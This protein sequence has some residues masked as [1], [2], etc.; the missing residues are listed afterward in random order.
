MKLP[1]TDHQVA[2]ADRLLDGFCAERHHLVIALTGAHAYGF[3]S[4][5]SDLDLKGVHILPTARL[6][7]LSRPDDHAGFMEVVEGVEIDYG[8]NELGQVIAGVLRGYG[9]YLERILGMWIVRA[10]EQHAELQHVV[11]RALSRRV[12]AHYHGF[13]SG[14]LK[15][16]LASG[17]PTAKKLL[18]VLRTGLT[19]THLLHT[20]SLV[21]D[22]TALMDEHGFGDARELL[23]V[24][25]AGER[26]VLPAPLAAKWLERVRSV[27]D[28]LDLA[29]ERSV[30][31]PEP[32][33]ATEVEQW[34]VAVRRA[35]FD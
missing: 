3:P 35:H 22:L 19:G 7:G 25:Q 15:A 16:A 4:P 33:N 12:H 26:Q 13:A 1:L 30:L 24:K 8:S 6:V 21:T 11:R 34:L 31:P 9:S 32:A 28:A 5:D 17:A 2:V 14:Q 10:S 23:E 27:F 29:R 18:Y 20:G